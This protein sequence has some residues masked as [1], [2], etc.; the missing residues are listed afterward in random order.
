MNKK[1]QNYLMKQGYEAL[2]FNEKAIYIAKTYLTGIKTEDEFRKELIVI[3]NK[4]IEKLRQ[5]LYWEKM[6]R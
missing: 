5:Q 4:E 3:M 1:A 6:K 2:V